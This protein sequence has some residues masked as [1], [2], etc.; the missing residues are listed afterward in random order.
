[1]KVFPASYEPVECPEDQNSAQ[2]GPRIVHIHPGDRLRGWKWKENAD[3]Y[4]IDDPKDVDW[5]APSAEVERT[6]G[7][8]VR[9]MA[10]PFKGD[11][12]DRNQVRD[13]KRKCR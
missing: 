12:C 6:P 2:Y 1:M 3:I 7:H 4:R 5:K 9:V 8:V 13:V 10:Q 11:E